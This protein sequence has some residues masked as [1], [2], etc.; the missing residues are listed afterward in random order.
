[1]RFAFSDEQRASQ[2]AV[3]ALLEKEVPPPVVRAAWGDDAGARTIGWS[4]LVEMGVV[5]LTVPEAHG[6]L[7]GDELDWALV[8]EEC[9]YAALPEPI[10]ET[11][12]VG[13]PLA[14]ELAGGERAAQWLSSVATAGATIAIG[15]DDDALVLDADRA[16]VI[17]LARV[18]AVHAVSPE[19]V[20]L[21]RQRSIDGA[22]RLFRVSGAL[23]ASSV[24]ARGDAAEGALARARERG[25]VAS[26]AFLLGLGRR[27]LDL[28]VA[29]VK[30][31][32][33][34][35]VPVGTFQA[36]KH[37]L[38]NAHIALELARPAVARAAYSL[39][40]R[41]PGREAWVSL[42]K[43]RASD[44][45]SLAG[46]V[47]LQ[48][49]GAIG[50]SFEHDLHLFLK[51]T[52]ALAASFGDAA[53][54]RARIASVV[55][56]RD[57]ATVQLEPMLRRHAARGAQ[58]TM[59]EAYI[60]DAV[61]TPVGKR[62]GGLSAVHPIDLGA[63]V[64]RALIERTKIDPATVEDVI[65]GCVDTIGPQAGDVARN[66][67]LAAGLPDEVPGVTVDRQC[68]SSQQAVHFAAQA[69]M[70]GTSD[71]VVAGGV[72]NMSMIP[73][74]AAMTTGK[75]L[76][77]PERLIGSSGWRERYGTAPI[78]QFRSAQMIADKWKIT[79]EDMEAFALESHRRAVRAIEEGRFAREVSPLAGVK[80]D[81]GPRPDTNLAKMATLKPVEE[82]GT[83]TAAVSSQ[84]SDG[85][86][87]ILVASERAV[88]EWGLRPRARIHHLSV[89]GA[90]PVW[91]LTAPIP[92][93]VH[94]LK[95]A[96]MKLDDIDLVEI[97]EAFA[98]V[99]LAWERELA[100]DHAKVNVNGGA[101][102]LGHPLGATGA[103]LMTTLL[104]ELERTGKRWGLQTMCEG[105]G[106]A[107]VTILERLL[108][109][110]KA[111]LELVTTDAK[112]SPPRTAAKPRVAK[113]QKATQDR[114]NR[115]LDVAVEL[116]EKGGFENVRQRDVAAQ[117]GVA[118]GT[119]Y[120]RFP[121]KEGLLCAALE[122]EA[123]AL[124]R[125][126]EDEPAK[127]SGVAGRI[128]A[129]FEVATRTL[130]KK[131]NFARAVIRAMASGEPDIA[132]NV[133]AY[134]GRLSGLVIAAMQEKGRLDPGDATASAPSGDEITMS[135]LLL[136][137]WY[138]ALVGWSAGLMTTK[139]VV[140]QVE[141]AA[142]L[143]VRATRAK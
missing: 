57:P 128:V 125:R 17:V 87:A 20:T 114:Q 77:M 68:G 94:A 82:G 8:I 24:I 92:A 47:S 133:A 39:A 134:Y 142:G 48:C 101:I 98:S 23:P 116:A 56:D 16:A 50:Y 126:M 33:Q 21:A 136:Q 109:P 111:K 89:R 93:T 37:H 41:E 140:A 19:S 85:A 103:R 9:G 40:R 118:L 76:D 139:G 117:A 71:L 7:G 46:R 62:K 43:A 127:G 69:V 96:G 115:I 113:P 80:H 22:R 15:L 88:K 120:K 64:L 141:S 105:G 104:S 137:V 84:I 12:A 53:S 91:M 31:R 25:A 54:H 3:R 45:A 78:S 138:A 42:A 122:R 124:E 38:A 107:N 90:D 100:V 58:T 63:H 13:V 70:S 81:E 83:I 2:R 5:G 130:C 35:G 49:H 102:A 110:V 60:I 95:R 14:A 99:V 135:Y 34:F 10:I 123:A 108:V 55:L 30:I 61:R 29:H 73:I 44:A 28:A 97:N 106:Q 4:R 67:W 36:V 51:R 119:L 26:A 65:F 1:M 112:T 132:G 66:C 143:L 6:G 74:G 11:T 18:G 129:F 86:A 59:A 131:P 72:Q 32:T 75:E 121:S 52:W 79:R 27:M